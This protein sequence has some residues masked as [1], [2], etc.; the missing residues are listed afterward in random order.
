MVVLLCQNTQDSIVFQNQW[1]TRSLKSLK[2]TSKQNK[3]KYTGKKYAEIDE[4]IKPS[5]TH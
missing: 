2:Q 4:K 3:Q 1:K 5:K